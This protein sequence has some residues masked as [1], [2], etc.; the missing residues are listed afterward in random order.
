[1][2]VKKANK[3]LWNNFRFFRNAALLPAEESTRCISLLEGVLSALRKR[4]VFAFV[5]NN[6]CFSL[7]F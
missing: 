3:S 4:F 7:D 1:M 2:A 6:A 5:G